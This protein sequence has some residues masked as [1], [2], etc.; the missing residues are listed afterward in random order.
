MPLKV[1]SFSTIK[2]RDTVDRR[3]APRFIG[4]SALRLKIGVMA[5]RLSYL[6]SNR[7]NQGHNQS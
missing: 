1:F 6:G 3:G 4:Q 7:G 2:P 5:G